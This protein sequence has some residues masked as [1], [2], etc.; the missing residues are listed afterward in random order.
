MIISTIR[1]IQA[2]ANLLTGHEP[3]VDPADLTE[4]WS[5]YYRW[6]TNWIAEDPANVDPMQM[7]LDFMHWCHQHIDNAERKR[8]AANYDLI[9]AAITNPVNSY[10]P[11]D[12]ILHELPDLK[13]L[14]P[15]WIPRGMLTVFAAQQGTGKSYAALDIARRIAAGG[16]FPDGA[17]VED[18]R[19]VLYIDTENSPAVFKQRMALWSKSERRRFYY[20][21]PASDRPGINLDSEPDRD[22]L[23]D[24]ICV[25]KPCLVTIDSYG[26]STL[27]SEKNKEDVQDLLAF[28]TRVSVDHDLA[29][30]LVH[31]L[32]KKSDDQQTFSLMSID[33]IRGSSL[34]TALARSVLGMQLIPSGPHADKKDPRQ[35]WVM[36]SNLAE[37]PRPLGVSLTPHPDDPKLAHVQYTKTLPRPY[38]EPTKLFQCMDWLSA[39]LQDEEEPLK[40]RDILEMGEEEGYGQR[41]IHRARQR[42]GKRIQDTADRNNPENYWK[43]VGDDE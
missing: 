26:S 36:K 11:I 43:W 20:A 14:W 34:I 33:A 17:P 29:M 2:I 4:P 22:R 7:R 41:M 1:K 24:W 18:D 31:H 13:W 38:Q 30:K 8:H 32:R 25:I 3:G 19:P 9:S 5:T 23:V 27:R 28:L 12:D 21:L 42:L 16:Q 37:L 35:L 39:L 40:P 6:I 15:G 10:K